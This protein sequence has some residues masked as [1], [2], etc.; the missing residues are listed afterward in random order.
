MTKNINK[1]DF[2]RISHP[3]FKNV[4]AQ[5]AIELMKSASNGDY[6]IRPSSQGPEYLTITWKFFNKVIVH[7]K[8]RCEHRGMNS[9]NMTYRI[10]E[11]DNRNYNSLEDIVDKCIKPMNIL[12]QDVVSNRKFFDSII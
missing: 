5:P 10:E 2:R 4:S 7:I 8:I 1:P 12:V 11:K 9:M 6:V 3:K